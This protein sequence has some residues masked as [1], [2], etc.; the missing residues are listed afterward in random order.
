MNFT[1]SAR[2]QELPVEKLSL[3]PNPTYDQTLLRVQLRERADLKIQLISP[4]GQVLRQVQLSGVQQADVPINLA[5]LPAGMYF[6]RL[7]ANGRQR[8]ERVVKF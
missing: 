2:D 5:Q 6:V 4:I 7:E 1:V 3:A 8:V